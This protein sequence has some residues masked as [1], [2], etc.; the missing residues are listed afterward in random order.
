MI[1]ACAHRA[2]FISAKGHIGLAPWNAREGDK[3]CILLGGCTPFLL[4]PVGGESKQYTLVGESYVQ[5]LM[6][7]E[8]FNAKE[9]VEMETIEII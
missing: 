9:G 8:A 5:G 3:I 7:G 2:M 1:R 6:A 4:R